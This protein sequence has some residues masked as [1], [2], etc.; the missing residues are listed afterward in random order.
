M[1]RRVIDTA[2]MQS[3]TFLAFM[4]GSCF[5]AGLVIGLACR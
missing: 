2:L 3:D 4:C 5:L 1:G